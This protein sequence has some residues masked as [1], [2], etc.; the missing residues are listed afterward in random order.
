VARLAPDR[1]RRPKASREGQQGFE[2]LASFPKPV[3]AAI[4]GACL[5]G[6]L[7]WALACHGRVASD[8]PRTQLG[9]PEVQLGLL[10]GAGGT[11]RLPRLIGVQAALDLILSGNP[12]RASKGRKLGLVDEVVPR[13]ILIDVAVEQA[14]VLAAAGGKTAHHGPRRSP[15]ETVTRAALEGNPIGRK[16]LF[17]E[18]RKQLL[19]K[20]GGYLPGPGAR[21]G[22]GPRGRGEGFEAGP[23][24]V[25]LRRAAGHRG[26]R[27]APRAS[28]PPPRSRRTPASTARRN[29]G[30]CTRSRCSAAASWAAASPS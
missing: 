2:R 11:Q 16:L 18:A 7:E 3:V 27:P 23:R 6:G 9:V 1:G 29:R 28:S 10:P 30:P 4:H 14:Q 19:R 5:G 26:E 12:V 24:R 25:R 13:S 20:S 21:A 22:G 8:A 17:A 15:R